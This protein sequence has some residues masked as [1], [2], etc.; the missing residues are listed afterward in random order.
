MT[1][2]DAAALQEAEF[3]LR[4]RGLLT[5]EMAEA[6]DAVFDDCVLTLREAQDLAAAR[7][8]LERGEFTP[9]VDVALE[10]ILAWV[11]EVYGISPQRVLQRS[12]SKLVVEAR[13]AAMY[14]ARTLTSMSL[15][16]LGRAFGRDHTTVLHAVR[17]I[18]QERLRDNGLHQRLQRLEVRAQDVRLKRT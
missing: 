12:R 15:T 8:A 11:H 17:K 3:R 14:L 7:D 1:F 10:L 9:Q 4:E 16:E 2:D 13:S 6:F 18:E 5:A